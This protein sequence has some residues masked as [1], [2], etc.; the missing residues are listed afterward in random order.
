MV[1]NINQKIEKD[2]IPRSSLSTVNLK[3][4]TVFGY[5]NVCKPVTKNIRFMDCCVFFTFCFI[6]IVKAKCFF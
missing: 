6:C 4:N 3:H 2:I 5:M 1:P